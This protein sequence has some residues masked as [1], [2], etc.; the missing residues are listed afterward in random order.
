MRSVSWMSPHRL[1][2]SD[3]YAV[4]VRS[5]YGGRFVPGQ[6]GIQGV[7]P[8]HHPTAIAAQLRHPL[9]GQLPS[10]DLL[11]RGT[12]SSKSTIMTSASNERARSS[13]LGRLPGTKIMLLIKIK[14]EPFVAG[15][16]EW[17]LFV[18]PRPGEVRYRIKRIST[19]RSKARPTTVGGE[20]RQTQSLGQAQ[21]CPVP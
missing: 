5:N 17:V 10:V 15:Q 1:G 7:Y 12:E 19:S 14:S 8:H 6:T 18:K 16:R 11:C 2:L 9:P 4:Q 21:T 20:G 3:A 13:M